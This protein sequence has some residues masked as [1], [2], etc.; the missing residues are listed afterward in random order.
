M[1]G[2]GCDPSKE[3]GPVGDGC[4][5][6]VSASKGDDATGDG[7]KAKPYKSLGKGVASVASGK[8]V[9]AC[10]ESFSEA[11]TLKSGVSLYGGLE[12]ATDWR[13]VA[14]KKTQLTAEADAIPLTVVKGDGSSEIA[15]VAIMSKD[16]VK[17]GGSSIAVLAVEAKA[18]LARVD[19]TAGKGAPGADGK[20]DADPTLKGE[21]GTP[22]EAGCAGK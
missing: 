16:A 17:A 20:D 4:G 7:S 15:D 14:S 1:T 11:L 2:A 21:D 22:G 9:Y 18:T 3:G 6:F 19:L 5:V 13:Y 12:C 8:A 10:G